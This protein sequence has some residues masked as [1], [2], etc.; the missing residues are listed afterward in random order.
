MHTFTYANLQRMKAITVRLSDDEYEK[1]RFEAYEAR[2]SIGKRAA[3]FLGMALGKLSKTEV[4]QRISALP[5]HTVD[6][7]LQQEGTESVPKKGVEVPMSVPANTVEAAKERL[8]E[9]EKKPT[10][11]ST[12]ESEEVYL[13]RMEKSNKEQEKRYGK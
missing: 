7:A 9:I 12:G 11:M 1:L 13:K 5:V 2:E 10:R 4:K 3:L 6:K 8:E